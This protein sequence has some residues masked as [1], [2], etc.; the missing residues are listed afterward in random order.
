MSAGT[1]G[2]ID[3]LGLSRARLLEH[4][5]HFGFKS[6]HANS[7]LRQVHQDQ[8]LDIGKVSLRAD[9]RSSIASC[10]QLC[11]PQA[12]IITTAT[13]GT[14]KLLFEFDDGSQVE[15]VIIPQGRRN[16]LCVSSQ[17]GCA[18]K[19]AFC[20]TG[21][22]GF[23]RN[24]SAAEIIAQ[25]WFAQRFLGARGRAITNLVFMGMGEPLLNFSAVKQAIEIV[26]DDHAYSLGPHKVSVSTVGYVPYMR[27]IARQTDVCLVVSLHAPSDAL[28][29][30]LVPINRKYPLKALFAA[31]RDYLAHRPPGEKLLFAYTLLAGVNDQIEHAAQLAELLRTELEGGERLRNIPAKVNLI[32]FNPFPGT[33]FSSPADD[34]VISFREHLVQRGVVSV[35]RR[36][37]G[38][39]IAAACGQLVGAGSV[40]AVPEPSAVVK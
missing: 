33:K 9:L 15:S 1:I 5:A 18:L 27:A 35:I 17:A 34:I 25:L 29:N 14:V 3:I 40:P 12:P 13:D 7:I 24:L 32:P 26:R 2:Q 37:R 38:D 21:Q 16:T 8:I 4:F 22:G 6:Q 10:S 30:Q 20:A 39:D 19:C 28:R 36:P 23:T 11:L 31:C